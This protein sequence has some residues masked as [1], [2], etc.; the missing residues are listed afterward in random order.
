MKGLMLYLWLKI[1][2]TPAARSVN[3]DVDLPNDSQSDTNAVLPRLLGYT[4]LAAGIVCVI[5]LVSAGIMYITAA[6]DPG[7]M[8]NAKKAIQYAITGL[9]IVILAYG[10]TLFVMKALG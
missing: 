7:K 4:Y 5:I 8:T 1:V 3:V 9:V 6:G 2:S 10:I